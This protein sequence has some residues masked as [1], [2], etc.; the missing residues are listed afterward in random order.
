M[1]RIEEYHQ[2]RVSF[3]ENSPYKYIL[4]ANVDKGSSFLELAR[5]CLNAKQGNM[6]KEVHI[7][8]PQTYFY[9]FI[10]KLSALPS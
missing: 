10:P 2:T 8:A 9:L 1:V 6:N 7:H 5:V 4:M 3:Y